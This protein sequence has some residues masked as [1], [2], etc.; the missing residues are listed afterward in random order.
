MLQWEKS[1]TSNNLILQSGKKKGGDWRAGRTEGW[2]DWDR[3][4]HSKYWLIW[5]KA[6]TRTLPRKLHSFIICE[7][8]LYR[9]GGNRV[10]NSSLLHRGNPNMH[11]FRLC[12][13]VMSHKS[14]PWSYRRPSLRGLDCRFCHAFCFSY[15]YVQSQREWL[16]FS[17]MREMKWNEM[18]A[19]ITGIIG[20]KQLKLKH[21]AYLFPFSFLF[22]KVCKLQKTGNL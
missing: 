11:P 14:N 22:L 10:L 1:G 12:G 21:K 2:S 5:Q 16:V 19:P 7:V 13:S 18:K 17:R 15:R 3:T 4:K 9:D 6:K 20:N 8:A